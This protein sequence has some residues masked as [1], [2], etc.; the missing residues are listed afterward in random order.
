MTD[1]K[2]PPLSL[3][4]KAVEVAT[5][6]VIDDAAQEKAAALKALDMAIPDPLL[7][8]NTT[9]LDGAPIMADATQT[10]QGLL[11]LLPIGL[12]V[13]GLKNTAEVWNESACQIVAERTIPV[14]KKYALGLK[15]I[16]FLETG[17]GIEEMA[18]ATALLPIGLASYRGYQ[19]DLEA[20]NADTE[21]T[22]ETDLNFTK[23]EG[24]H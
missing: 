7:E 9:A 12:S 10:L 21:K 2:K 6:P 3:P 8:A 4:K 15:I 18:L 19:L 20:K 14:L 1:E 13:V 11:S 22:G 5:A 23:A 16:K 17:S 24:V